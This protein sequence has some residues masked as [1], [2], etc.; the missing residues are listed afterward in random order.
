MGDRL[1]EGAGQGNGLGLRLELLRKYLF[2]LS[3]AGFPA[4]KYFVVVDAS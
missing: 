3:I 1:A 4:L 2:Y